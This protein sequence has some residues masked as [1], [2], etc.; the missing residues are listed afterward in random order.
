MNYL[1]ILVQEPAAVFAEFVAL[2]EDCAD[3]YPNHP[4][5]LLLAFTPGDLDGQSSTVKFWLASRST[6]EKALGASRSIGLGWKDYDQ[7]FRLKKARNPAMSWATV[8]QELWLLYIHSVQSNTPSPRVYMVN[9]KRKYC[10]F[11]NK[12]ACMLPQYR[13]LHKCLIVTALDKDFDHLAKTA[14]QNLQI[15][16]ASYNGIMYPLSFC[17]PWPASDIFWKQ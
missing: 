3:V 5:Y 4:T 13:Y 15:Y 10:E 7:E 12:G 8:D 17:F 11:N 2:D 6:E 9:T 16:Y 14:T 1:Q